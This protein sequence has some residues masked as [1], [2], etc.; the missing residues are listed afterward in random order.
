VGWSYSGS[1]DYQSRRG[2]RK[3]EVRTVT[4][5]LVIRRR[6][7]GCAR[8][9]APGTSLLRLPTSNQATLVSKPATKLG[10]R[11]LRRL[12]RPIGTVCFFHAVDLGQAHDPHGSDVEPFASH[13]KR[14]VP[15]L[16]A[17]LRYL[18]K[19]QGSLLTMAGNLHLFGLRAD[20]A[21]QTVSKYI[22]SFAL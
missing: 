14:L 6:K 16:R 20:P 5:L 4:N 2:R 18:Q 12:R 15:K 19:E 11:P 17:F 21:S 10:N 3:P 7:L 22:I 9:L 8:K 1:A 13:I